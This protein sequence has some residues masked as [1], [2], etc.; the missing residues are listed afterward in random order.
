MP[1]VRRARS[2]QVNAVQAGGL[3]AAF[4][5][6]SVVGGLLASGMIMP[7]VAST[8]ALTNASV[9]LFDELPGAL[10]PQ[11]LSEKSTILAA[12]GTKLAEVYEQNRIVVPLAEISLPM[13]RAVIDTEDKRFYDHGGVDLHGMARALIKNAVSD[14]V[15]GASTLTQQYIKNTLVQAAEDIEDGTER[16]KAIAAAKGTDGSSGYARKLREAKLAVTLEQRMTKAQILEGYLNVAQFGVSVYGVEAAAQ[17]YFSVSAKDLTYLQAATIAGVTNSPTAF[18]PIRN[19]KKSEQR[20][21]IVLKRMHEQGD[22][23]QAEYD[24]GIATPLPTTLVPGQAKIGCT[25]A[26]AAVP[27]SSYFCDYVLKIMASNP[28]FGEDKTT[29]RNLLYKGGLT[30]HTTLDPAKQAMANQAV[31]EQIPPADPS[32][33]AIAMSVVEPGTGKVLAMAQDTIYDTAPTPPPGHTAVNYNAG[34]AFGGSS[35]FEPGS[36]FKPFTLLEWLK[37]GR[38][39]KDIVDGT[40]KTWKLNVFHGSCPEYPGPGPDWKLGNSEGGA[41]FMSVLDATK[42]SVNNAYAD[43][44]SQLDMCGIFKGAQDLGVFK[45]NGDPLGMNP[46]SVIGAAND[47]A[48]LTMAAA[49]AAFSADGIYCAPIAI[50]AIEDPDGN[51]VP[52]PDAGC[53]QAI[54]PDLAAGVTYGLSQVWSGTGKRIAKLP[55]GRPASGKTGTTTLNEHTWFVGYTKQLATAVWVGDPNARRSMNG[56]TINGKYYRSGP[57]GASIAGPAWASFMIPASE[58][59]P[60]L[61]FTQPPTAMVKGVQVSVPD[62][63]GLS[64]DAAKKK[65]KDAK[66]NAQVADGQVP[67]QYPAGTVAGSDPGT[68]TK[69]DRGTAVQILVSSGAPAVPTGWPG[70]GNT[71]GQQPPGQGG[72]GGGQQPPGHTNPGKP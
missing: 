1:S 21:N 33:A 40:P 9:G 24:Q 13:Q 32:G 30:I 35:G 63:A 42:N 49:F 34:K 56:Q 11:P 62:I 20:R 45:G 65:L 16:A 61:G 28:V 25:T 72:G 57:Y 52:V 50:T 43:M 47:V 39:L 41:G 68:G 60:V 38:S 44:A 71:G 66:L 29:R 18:D 3:L 70:P 15:E 53:H 37:E 2:R 31:M 23:T 67:S 48:P 27:G 12:D 5:G 64:V 36:T 59:M 51:P 7:A 4:V 26:D 46:S 14:E 10:E 22:I 8:S 19:P 55:D 6:V 58:G 69:V 17:L 54:T